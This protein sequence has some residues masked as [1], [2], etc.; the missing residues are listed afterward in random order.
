[1]V[2]KMNNFEKSKYSNLNVLP[3]DRLD[4]SNK[5]T[6]VRSF[7]AM[8]DDWREACSYWKQY[9]DKFIDFIKPP[10]CKIDLYP[11]QRIWLRILL[12]YRKVFVTATRGT[13]KS[14][15]EILALY[16]RCIFFP[17][18]ELFICA[19]GKEQASNIAKANIEK[20]WSYFPLLK[21]EIEH[22]TFGKDYTRLVFHNGS[23]FDVVQVEQSARGGRKFVC[24]LLLVI[25]I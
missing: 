15:T 20:I 9:P 2:M 1:M 25:V 16:L 23:Y 10:D 5:D 12:R 24:V 3:D 18:V 4:S 8:K 11:Y 19:P 13:A 21:N 22:Y 6:S 17:G 14:F 7:E